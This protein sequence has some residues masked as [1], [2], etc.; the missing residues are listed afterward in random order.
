LSNAIPPETGGTFPEE[1]S[2]STA[3]PP[4]EFV[5]SGLTVAATQA[6]TE[7]MFR[8]WPVEGSKSLARIAYD[9]EGC[10]PPPNGFTSL[11]WH[12]SHGAGLLHLLDAAT[13]TDVQLEWLHQRRPDYLAAFSTNI[14]RLARCAIDRKLDLTFALVMS[15]GTRVDPAIRDDCRTAFHAEIVDS[16]GSQEVGHV[17][18]Q[19]PNC[20]EY[21][22]AVETTRIEVL[23]DGDD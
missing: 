13:E 11:G 20:G 15:F 22:L 2:G 7:R 1:T 16:Y 19:C 14:H 10:A 18:T 17:A 4:F 6:L 21:H 9:K 8:W 3:L 5:K 23:R 12:S